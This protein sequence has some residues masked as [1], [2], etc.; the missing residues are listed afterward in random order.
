[1]ASAGVMVAAAEGT[2]RGG[3]GGLHRRRRPDEGSR[4][5]A[6]EVGHLGVGGVEPVALSRLAPH[7]LQRRVVDR[8]GVGRGDRRLEVEP[9]LA[10]HVA[11][12]AQEGPCRGP[13]VG[14]RRGR[15]V[16]GVTFHLAP[17][18]SV[19]AGE[20]G[21]VEVGGRAR[22]QRRAR[23][24]AQR[25]AVAPPLHE[26]VDHADARRRGD[27]HRRGL[28]H[29]VGQR[30]LRRARSG[31]RRPARRPG[32]RATTGRAP[33]SSGCR[34]PR[35]TPGRCGRCRGPPRWR[36]APVS[37]FST[38]SGLMGSARGL[39]ETPACL[40]LVA[41]SASSFSVRGGCSGSSPARVKCARLR[42]S[43]GV[44]RVVAPAQCFLF[45]RVGGAHR[46][47]RRGRVLLGALPAGRGGHDHLR[48]GHGLGVLAAQHHDGGQGA[49]RGRGGH[50][51]VEAGLLGRARA[52][53]VEH[54]LHLALAGVVAGH[55]P[56][57]GGLHPTLVGLPHGDHDGL[58]G[59][60]GG[61][62]RGQLAAVGGRLRVGRPSPRC[63]SRTSCRH[64]P[65]PPGPSSARA[66]AP[67]LLVGSSG[68]P[69]RA[70]AAR[71]SHPSWPPGSGRDPGGQGHEGGRRG[72]RVRSSRCC[73]AGGRR[74]RP[75][76]PRRGRPGAPCR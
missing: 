3:D 6:V 51:G 36:P 22:R 37:Q 64:T 9:H 17:S 60:V 57:Q 10:G 54:H 30:R 70:I 72:G 24:Q 46:R 66:R 38:S 31:A 39:A 33:A 41:T 20:G 44:S 62:G 43:T 71:R 53:G 2:E 1:M 45:D 61:G 56:L 12:E 21:D 13:L 67:P 42:Y 26:G 5:L 8:L 52:G 25:V 11:Q 49:G 7:G 47:Q 59:G 48:V 73:S 34:T 27:G 55:H 28:G 23:R 19:Q 76:A 32:R 58:G 74:R 35:P 50:R 29:Q 18:G 15:D 40:S 75:L 63:R 68:R 14:G 4:C 16:P 65:R 69:Y